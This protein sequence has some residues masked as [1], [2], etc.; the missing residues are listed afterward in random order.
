[1]YQQDNSLQD[2]FQVEDFPPD[3]VDPSQESHSRDTNALI[4]DERE[5]LRKLHAA[6]A[7]ADFEYQFLQVVRMLTANP[8]QATDTVPSDPSDFDNVLPNLEQI[9]RDVST[10]LRVEI[11]KEVDAFFRKLEQLEIARSF[12]RNMIGFTS[13]RQQ[14]AFRHLCRE[15]GIEIAWRRNH[16]Q[17][18]QEK[19]SQTLRELNFGED[20]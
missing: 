4:P 13:G 14:T 17:W 5:G 16:L 7:L 9:R 18:W 15:Q 6:R 12:N 1:M 3:P 20:I 11:Q 10:R 19:C 2:P 8:S